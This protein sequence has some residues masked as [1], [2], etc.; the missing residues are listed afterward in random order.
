LTTCHPPAVFINSRTVA[1][2][3]RVA[4]HKRHLPFLAGSAQHRDTVPA[5]FSRTQG[6]T[7]RRTGPLCEVLIM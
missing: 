6:N 3:G 7:D 2:Q 1:L 5:V 4:V